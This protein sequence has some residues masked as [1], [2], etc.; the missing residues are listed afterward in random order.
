LSTA[1]IGVLHGL[2]AAATSAA[3]RPRSV[4]E[5]AC[6]FCAIGASRCAVRALLEGVV[7]KRDDAF[8][9]RPHTSAAFAHDI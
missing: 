6:R 7:P 5:N 4:R 9:W 2:L 8:S 1:P 3:C